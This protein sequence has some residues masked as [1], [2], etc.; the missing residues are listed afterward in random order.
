MKHDAELI[1]H[2]KCNCHPLMGLAAPYAPDLVVAE[3]AGLEGVT[4]PG[5]QLLPG[6]PSLVLI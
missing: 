6:I 1:E 5:Q 2:S 3:S 4:L